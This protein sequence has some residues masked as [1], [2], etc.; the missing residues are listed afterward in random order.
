MSTVTSKVAS[1]V[2]YSAQRQ[3]FSVPQ[4]HR[5]L[6]PRDTGLCCPQTQVFVA[7]RHRVSVPLR[8]TVSVS[9]RHRVSAP[10]RPAKK[11]DFRIET[12]GVRDE[13]WGKFRAMPGEFLRQNQQIQQQ[14][15]MMIM[16]PEEETKF[17]KSFRGPK[18][19]FL[20]ELRGGVRTV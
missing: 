3:G 11:I 8:H 7:Q 16:G 18:L 6:L 19:G 17:S 20:S 12:S 14:Q 2:T 5:T 4:R 10:D 9:Q 15:S 13:T 1:N